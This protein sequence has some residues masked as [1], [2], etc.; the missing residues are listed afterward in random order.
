MNTI[1]EATGITGRGS[2]RN[3]RRNIIPG[4][5][6]RVFFLLIICLLLFSSS[7][8][9]PYGTETIITTDSVA[10]AQTSPALYGDRIVWADARDITIHLYN[11]TTGK[12]T[13]LPSYLLE[14]KSPSLYGDTIVWQDLDSFSQYKIIMY[15][16]TTATTDSIDVYNDWIQSTN[17]KIYRDEVVWQDF[18]SGTEWNVYLYNITTGIQTAIT[19]VTNGINEKSPAL[20]DNF[21]VYENWSDPSAFPD[22]WL[23]NIS[24]STA[25]QISKV[26]GPE[27]FP[28]IYGSKIVWT[29]PDHHNPSKYRIYL[30]DAGTIIPIS[31]PSDP[32]IVGNPSIYGDRV[33]YNDYRGT[34]GTYVEIYM[35][36]IPHAREYQLVP[37]TGA[38]D[39]KLPKIYGNRIA[40]EDGRAGASCMGCDSDIYLLTLGPVEICPV[41][42][43][44]PKNN[45]GGN[46]F[47]IQLTDTSTSGTSGISHRFWNFSDGSS[48]DT[49]PNPLHHFTT[50]V[51]PV[52]LTVGNTK[53]RNTTPDV[54]AYRVYSG[55][56]PLPD[57]TTTP[58]AGFAPLI[59]MFTDRSC[60]K[61]TDWTWDFGD[62]HSSI[63]QNPAH[64]YTQSG[65]SFDVSL[66]TDNGFGPNTTV[67]NNLVRTFLGNTDTSDTNIDGITVDHRFGAGLTS[68]TVDTTKVP[69]FNLAVPTL[70]LYPPLAYGWTNLTVTASDAPGFSLSGSSIGGN[71]STST[72]WTSDVTVP[73][74]S[75]T[76]GSGWGANYRLNHIAFPIPAS[77]RTEIWESTLPTDE[78]DAR[79]V[80]TS[81]NRIL[82]GTA[83]TVNITK[84]NLTA[85][86]NAVIN[87]SID[88]GAPW[89]GADPSDV[90]VIG[91]GWLPTGD[92]VGAILQTD[93][94]SAGGS[95]YFSGTAP[96]SLTK[97][98][99][100]KVS[101]SGN[102]FQLITL[103]VSTRAA[104]ASNNP[105]TET[106]DNPSFPPSAAPGAAIPGQPTQL[107]TPAPPAVSE[108]KTTGL[109]INYLGVVT[110]TT[111]LESVDQLAT[112]AIGQGITAFDTSGKPLSSVSIKPLAPS[113]VPSI[114]E[115]T[116]L[117]F[118]GIAYELQ[119]DG[120]QFSPSI[121]VTFTVP[122]AQWG[123]HYTVMEFDRATQTWIDLPTTDNPSSGTISASVNHFCCIALFAENFNAPQT[124]RPTS[125]PSQIPTQVNSPPAG[126]IGIFTGL[127]L[128]CAEVFTKNIYL[129]L[130]V[131]VVVILVYLK[132]RKK[133][134]A[135][136]RY[137][138]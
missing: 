64:M 136:V 77:I 10:S 96:N 23:Y 55:S 4:A 30:Y 114:P 31:P 115:G 43:F 65:R 89:L 28:D 36:D 132:G 18:G 52:M 22:I 35:Y 131:L 104:P 74:N 16:T 7:S 80:A 3:L 51:Y 97:F 100:A 112:V 84:I 29:G 118:A 92:R 79:S 128:W 62:G 2:G 126:A 67:Y 78:A 135:R 86:G 48:F 87:M 39:L 63:Q 6:Y 26:D 122:N 44:I 56:P 137:K 93:H 38:F 130:F 117:K 110:Q 134:L 101:G 46:P 106:S 119:P 95:E 9:S 19:G 125:I 82:R 33:V 120:A 42:G 15:N 71:V 14:P 54:C 34:S 68:I 90:M 60:G 94:T 98:I 8:A 47:D 66:T 58:I 88:S 81:I 102:P 40:W 20:F 99:L 113:Q 41:A 123:Q 1:Q 12:E 72:L 75:P 85:N 121:T 73:D 138:L 49:I 111:L 13:V 21:I 5:K 70:M 69:H 91:L 129:V 11:L 24:N 133:R 57:F 45:V 108:A 127:M 109:Y 53:C 37:R 124:P 83:Y 59:V 25:V 105:G 27:R 17:P 50:G 32:N 76:L 61:P 103:S 107:Q 116:L